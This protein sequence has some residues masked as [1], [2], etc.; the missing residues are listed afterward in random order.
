MTK[1]KEYTEESGVNG[2]YDI[3]A[4][5]VKK[6]LTISEYKIRLMKAFKAKSNPI[7]PQTAIKI[8]NDVATEK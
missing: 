2:E 6:D 1:K 5:N 3:V 8:I 7:T 4:D